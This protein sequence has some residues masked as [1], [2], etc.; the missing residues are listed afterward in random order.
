MLGPDRTATGR[1]LT[2]VDEVAGRGV[3]PLREA[4][5]RRGARKRLD[6]RAERLARHRHDDEIGVGDRGLRDRRR[7]DVREIDLGHEARVATRLADGRR[8]L[9]AMSRDRD[10]EPVVGEEAREARA[11]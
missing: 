6:D 4:E 9:L 8:I 5:D 7:G 3:E 10:L 1:P 11:P 2:R